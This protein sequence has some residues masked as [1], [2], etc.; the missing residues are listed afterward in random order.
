MDASDVLGCQLSGRPETSIVSDLWLVIDE[1]PAEVLAAAV[2]S[3]AWLLQGA[4][5]Q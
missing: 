1:M 3:A 5:R 2:V 4:I